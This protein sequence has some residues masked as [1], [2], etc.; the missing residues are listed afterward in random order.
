VPTHVGEDVKKEELSSLAGRIG[1][2]YNHSGNQ[3]EG[4]SDNWK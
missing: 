1:N 4:S 3:S 2:W